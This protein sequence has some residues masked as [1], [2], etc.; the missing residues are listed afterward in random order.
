[1]SDSRNDLPSVDSPNFTQ[2]LRETVQ[3]YLGRQGDPLERGLTLRDLIESGLAKLPQGARL[4]PGAASVPLKPGDAIV[5]AYEPDLTPPP[6]PSGLVVT[7]A[8]SHIL[9]EHDAPLYSV[10]HGHLRTRVYGA[11]YTS[12]PLPV[13]SDAVE[14]AQFSGTTYALPANPAT[15]WHLWIKWETSDGVLSATP[16]GGTNGV[17]ATSGQDVSHL[18]EALTGKLQQ[19]QLDTSLSARINL[20]D[21]PASQDGSV[22]YRIGQESALRANAIAQEASTRAQAILDEAAA[23]SVADGA[24]QQQINMLSAAGSGD[25][26][27]LLAA[28]Q[29]EQTARV[30]GDTAEATARQALAAQMRGDYT[31][32]DPSALTTGLVYNERQARITAEGAIAS[33]VS[34]LSATVTNN[35]STLSAAIT[36][37]QTARA[38][39][40]SALTSSINTLSSKVDA[41]SSAIT[42]EQTT[43]SSA[44]SA[45]ASRASALESV[46]NSTTDGNAALKARIAS[47]EMARASG[48]TAISSTVT[49][50]TATVNTKNKTYRQASAPTSGMS[51]GDVWYD[52]DDGNK[53][54][55]YSG[56]TWE[57]TDDS[58]ISQSAAAI[59]AE[60]TARANADTALASSISSLSS[61]VDSNTAAITAEQTARATADSA[62]ASAREALAARVATVEGGVTSNS[63]AIQSE[64][65]ARASA[66]A[67][68]ATRIDTVQ[69]AA[70]GFDSAVAF[71]FDGALD[72]WLAAG[73]TATVEGSVVRLSAT[74][75]DPT[76]S[77]SGI[78]V[79]GATATSVRARIKRVSGTGWDGTVYYGTAGH[80]IVSGY[81]KTVS[82]SPVSNEW[83]VVEWDMSDLT[84]GGSDWVASTITS[85]R[86][87]LGVTSADVFD[88]DWIAVGRQ[89][90]QAY[91]AAIQTEATT[92]ATET[93]NLFAQYTV[94]VDVNGYVAGYGLASTARNGV[95]TSEF[96]VKADQFAIAPVQTDNTA[97]DGSPF[98]HR[99]TATTI[100]GVSVPAGTYMKAAYIHDATITNAKIADLAV[101]NAKI[102]NVSVGKLTAGSVAVGQ[103]VQS[104]SYTP[105]EQ[106]WRINGDGSAE[107]DF[108][109]VRG[110]LLAAQ[111]AA[112][113]ITADKIDSRGLTIKDASGVPI[114]QAGSAVDWSKL[115]GKVVNLTGLGYVGDLN[116]TNGA[117][118][119]SNISGIPYDK[120]Y[121]TDAATNLGFNPSF[122]SWTGQ[123][124]AGWGNWS[125]SGGTI[126]KDTTVVRFGSN[127]VK[128][129]ANGASQLGFQRRVGFGSPMPAGT[130]VSGSVDMYLESIVSAL[131][132]M[133][134]RLFVNAELTT[135]KD[136]FVLPSPTTGSW[137]K[138]PFSARVA[139]NQQIHGIQI[140]MMGAYGGWPASGGL[141]NGTVYFDGLSFSFNEASMDA[142]LKLN[143]AG[144]TI[145]GPVTFAT[146]GGILAA[147]DA[148][149]GVYL[150]PNGLVGKK[151]GNTTFAIDAAGNASFAGALSGATGTFAGSLSAASGTFSGVLTATAINAVNTLNI[152]GNAV[153]IP[154]AA[155]WSG[156]QMVSYN[157]DT[158]LVSTPVA[159]FEGGAVVISCLIY[160]DSYISSGDTV[161]RPIAPQISLYRN[162]VRLAIL[163]GWTGSAL[164]VY[165]Q[166][167]GGAVLS[168]LDSPGSADVTYSVRARGDYNSRFTAKS[169]TISVLGVKR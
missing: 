94:K 118:W 157:S 139:S 165:D 128:M 65:I 18:L 141:F 27:D 144:D 109:H 107:F 80:G 101:D 84:A 1:M 17:E 142:S 37:E 96:I 53:A 148:N 164:S 162:G 15:T 3:T 10:G 12:G 41:A 145:T 134:V 48:D 110:T 158:L 25:F 114:I 90:P 79:V 55:R 36:A 20:I 133:L 70:V 160:G 81:R 131:P 104:T 116:A 32:T 103:Y 13:F 5:G 92:R 99:T 129:V 33:S 60:Q 136:T 8:I 58:R 130:F 2:R 6:Q 45:L 4:R 46:V 86:L 159:N 121:S 9:I 22:A 49:A 71:N 24:L 63:S 102:A 151:A 38:N 76:F 169:A 117:D 125:S 154:V 132:M 156:S 61:K 82:S 135:Y 111:V 21:G 167:S 73:A 52:S 40:D 62:E 120:I 23:R 98:F 56:T 77:R 122:E 146:T 163:H 7:P 115:G 69:S 112:G 88:I 44:D 34:A 140:Y 57:P 143:K 64:A 137:Q 89:V 54:Y 153:T 42:A 108:A 66:D 127:S 166:S 83:M 91:T 106:G 155:S 95:P 50:L 68:L 161:I 168:Y 152:A 100:N 150:G 26:S 29:D 149:N 35:T 19:S 28:V 85:I 59:T 75:N 14:V 47:E 67:A 105:G 11:I 123:F 51:A 16:A 119:N 113:S 97:N 124:P 31:G 72:G 30:A 138:I 147:T 93:G 43:R 78:S 87:D 126:S 39:A 74:A